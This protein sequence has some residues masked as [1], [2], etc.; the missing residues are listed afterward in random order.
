MTV[1]AIPQSLIVTA[2]EDFTCS[3]GIDGSLH[4]WGA[5][6]VGQLGDGS[7]RNQFLP[8]RLALTDV[9]RVAAGQDHACAVAG[10]GAQ[11]YC[12]GANSSGQIGDGS[13]QGSTEPV[14]VGLAGVT[15][16]A[17][18]V[19]HTCAI[20]N[21]TVSCWGRNDPY[22]RL[23][24]TGTGRQRTPR[25]NGVVGV[26]Q[27]SGGDDF[28]CGLSA[29][30][31]SLGGVDR[32]TCWGRNRNNHLGRGERSDAELPGIA[33]GI[34]AVRRIASGADHT[35]ALTRS[36]LVYCWG[37][38]SRGQLGIGDSEPTVAV[39]RANALTDIEAIAAGGRHSCARGRNDRLRCW[40]NNSHGQLGLGD[41]D[42]RNSAVQLS[43]F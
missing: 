35:C 26:Y 18:G 40:G 11:F 13:L 2:G 24:W 15:N 17:L 12:W 37:S 41:Q 25:A 34:T 33:I 30:I 14:A 3:A 28:V 5:N 21:A 9:T 36:G 1:E 39:R 32:V 7:G 42:H 22:N 10:D 38:N 27:L 8:V 31:N 16:L 6:D 43:G 20:T 4:C 23:G 19:Q 29:R